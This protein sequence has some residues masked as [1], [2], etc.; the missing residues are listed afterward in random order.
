MALWPTIQDVNYYKL[1]RSVVDRWV[2]SHHMFLIDSCLET[3]YL[4]ARASEMRRRMPVGK[5]PVGLWE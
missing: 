3:F 1:Q 5:Q 4:H 2:Q